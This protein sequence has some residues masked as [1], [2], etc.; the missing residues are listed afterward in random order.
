ML[1]KFLIVS[2]TV[3][4][5]NHWSCLVCTW[6]ISSQK[7]IKGG[8]AEL[9]ASDMHIVDLLKT[10]LLFILYFFQFLP[11]YLSCLE[12]NS[13]NIFFPFL[14]LFTATYFHSKNA[15]CSRIHNNSQKRLKFQTR[16]KTFQYNC[17]QCQTLN[18]DKNWPRYCK[19][20]PSRGVG[21]QHPQQ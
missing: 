6:K 7:A 17:R 13:S 8:L 12:R 21:Q 5:K 20:R 16:L 15:F 14:T 18:L 2:S 1:P 9:V 3:L 19:M 11:Q 4:H 10:F